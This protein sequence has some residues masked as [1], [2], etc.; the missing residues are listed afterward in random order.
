MS[1]TLDEGNGSTKKIECQA[2]G[3]ILH[4]A[5]DV[6]SRPTAMEH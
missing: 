4:I 3:E 6:L 1:T 5:I 2:G